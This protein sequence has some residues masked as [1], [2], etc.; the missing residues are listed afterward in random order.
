MR[1]VAPQSTK[2]R[3]RILDSDD[4]ILWQSF[5]DVSKDTHVLVAKK[6]HFEKIDAKHL[7]KRHL[8][9][10]RLYVEVMDNKHRRRDFDQYIADE[11]S[12]IIKAGKKAVSNNLMQVLLCMKKHN[13]WLPLEVWSII[14]KCAFSAKE[15]EMHAFGLRVFGGTV[16]P[17]DSEYFSRI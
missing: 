7:Y 1:G 11:Q 12:M 3:R 10:R 14:I 6:V 13:L 5:Q 9:L 2:K 16:L 17:C 8:S 4:D 15:E